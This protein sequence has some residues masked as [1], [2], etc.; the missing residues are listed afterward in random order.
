MRKSRIGNSPSA[1]CC[2]FPPE[3]DFMVACTSNSIRILKPSVTLATVGAKRC[4]DD[5]NEVSDVLLMMAPHARSLS[6]F[7]SSS[8]VG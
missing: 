2:R 6:G 1:W 7:P 3:L 4:F 5:T 8:K